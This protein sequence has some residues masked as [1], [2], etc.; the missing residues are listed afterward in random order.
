MQLLYRHIVG[1]IVGFFEGSQDS[2][3]IS[4]MHKVLNPHAD[5]QPYSVNFSSPQGMSS[6]G[7][8]KLDLEL[9]SVSHTLLQK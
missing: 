5:T 8:Q 2:S 3:D 7:G 9:D 1:M 4:D 6:L